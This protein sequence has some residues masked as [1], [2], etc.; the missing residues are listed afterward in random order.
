MIVLPDSEARTVAQLKLYFSWFILRF[1]TLMEN[2]E[3]PTSCVRKIARESLTG[4]LAVPYFA[5]V[6]KKFSVPK[7]IWD[8]LPNRLAVGAQLLHSG[9]FQIFLLYILLTYFSLSY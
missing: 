6:C 9:S 1:V 5:F 3:A 2:P 8:S 4:D 7:I